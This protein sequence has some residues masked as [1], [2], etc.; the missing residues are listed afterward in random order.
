MT[1]RRLDRGMAQRKLSLMDEL[2]RDLASIGVV[3]AE[4]LTRDRVTRHAVER[5][6]TQL[7]QIAVDI[8]AHLASALGQPGPEDYRSSFAASAAAGVISP[9]LADRLMPSV[10]MRNLLIHEYASINLALVAEAAGRALQDYRAYVEAVAG[11]LTG[12]A[13]S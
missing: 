9:E 5:V 12:E 1:P 7:A 4:L 6:L 8:N 10:G 13:I 3:D 11:F 2:L